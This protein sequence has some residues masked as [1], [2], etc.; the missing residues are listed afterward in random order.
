MG[1]HSPP[2]PRPTRRAARHPAGTGEV[3]RVPT[4]WGIH[5]DVYC[6][7]GE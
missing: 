6:A 2:P 5:E 4:Q 1:K 7:V 3:A